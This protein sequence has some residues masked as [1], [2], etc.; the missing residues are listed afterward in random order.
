MVLK[1]LD[2]SHRVA[3][4]EI[5]IRNAEPLDLDA[6]VEVFLACWLVS[7][8]DL[9]PEDVRNDMS[10]ENARAL[11]EPSLKPRSN[12][13]MLIAQ[14]EDEIAGVALIGPEEMTLG[15]G[16][17]F[18]LYVHPSQSRGGIGK[19]LLTESIKRL[20]SSGFEEITV[21]V[22]K[23]NAI[24]EGLYKKFGFRVTGRQQTDDRW[25][26]PQIEMRLTRFTQ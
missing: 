1:S 15:L 19:A 14:T 8:R 2:S 16:H 24:A 12:R 7:Y 23:D 3:H 18:S 25:K 5:S 9:L 20:Q 13:E 6:I 26:I 11:W 4:V 22:F 10:D 21:W 17:L